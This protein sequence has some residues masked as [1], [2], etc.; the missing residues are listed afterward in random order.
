MKEFFYSADEEQFSFDTED[1]AIERQL[2]DCDSVGDLTVTIWKGES[3]IPV[4]SDEIEIMEFE[5]WEYMVRNI[6]EI[7]I[8]V[9][10]WQKEDGDWGWSRTQLLADALE[11]E[12]E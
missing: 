5:G 8:P 10:V 7:K 2:D 4:D 11:G 12:K 3:Y 6:E 9:V 1:E